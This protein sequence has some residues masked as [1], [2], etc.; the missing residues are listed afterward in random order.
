[1]HILLIQVGLPGFPAEAA[2]H[3]TILGIVP[4]L[5]GSA[6]D[7]A[8]ALGLVAGIGQDVLLADRFEQAQTDHRW[9]DP[10][11]EA[12][13][14][15]Q[16]TVAQLA[17]LQLRLAQ[18]DLRTVLE[19]HRHA[20]VGHPHLAFRGVT[21]DGHV[22][23]LRAID[24]FGHHAQALDLAQ[25]VR[26]VGQ[27]QAYQHGHCTYRVVLGRVAATVL[28]VAVLAGIGVE[29]RPQ[30]VARG[31]SGWRDDPRAAEETVAH[32]EIQAPDR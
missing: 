8:G 2:E 22:L 29:Q 19:A 3:G 12:C 9:R 5:I 6:L 28:D 25:V 27:R 18:F 4:Y 26:A 7:R 23:Q 14:G 11:R 31:G 32:A 24:G 1:M 30:A 15:M 13:I 20:L 10:R 16:I 21:G 17:D